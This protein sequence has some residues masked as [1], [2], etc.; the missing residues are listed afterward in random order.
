MKI[1]CHLYDI[2]YRSIVI[3]FNLLSQE[4]DNR[5]DFIFDYTSFRIIEL[6]LC[7]TKLSYNMF[8]DRECHNSKTET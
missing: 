2:I 5:F 4:N 6:F 8:P 1:F 7:T 3:L